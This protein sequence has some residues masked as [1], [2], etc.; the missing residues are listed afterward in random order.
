MSPWAASEQNSECG[1]EILSAL[2]CE[3]DIKNFKIKTVEEIQNVVNKF[4]SFFFLF[5]N[6]VC[7]RFF[8]Y[9]TF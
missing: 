5:Y 2:N 8:K 7:L 4:V 9:T 1:C 3:N 6:K